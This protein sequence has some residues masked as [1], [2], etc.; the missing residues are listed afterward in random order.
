RLKALNRKGRKEKPQSSQRLYPPLQE[1]GLQRLLDKQLIPCESDEILS[2][3]LTLQVSRKKHQDLAPCVRGVFRLVTCAVYGILK[4][5]AGVG[6]DCDVRLFPKLV[7]LLP[8]L[9]H[10]IGSDATIL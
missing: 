7:H 10:I 8:E 9:F 1:D 4:A 2:P 5:M 6:I 3:I